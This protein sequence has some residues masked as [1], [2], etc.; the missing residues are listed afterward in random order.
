MTFLF[1]VLNVTVFFGINGMNIKMV[2]GLPRITSD[3]ASPVTLRSNDSNDVVSFHDDD[4]LKIAL[5]MTFPN[6]GTTYTTHLVR[7]VTGH[8][9]A[10]N[11]GPELNGN[12]GKSVPIFELSPEGPFWSYASDPRF[13][14]P[15][16]GYILTKTHCG[17]YC[18]ICPPSKYIENPQIFLSNC[19]QS[20][21]TDNINN[22]TIAKVQLGKYDKEMISKAVHLIRDPFDNIVARFHWELHK[23][24]EQNQTKFLQQYPN[25]RDGFRSFCSDLREKFQKEEK[26]SMFFNDILSIA[27]DVPCYADFFR[28]IQWHNH[29]FTMAWDLAVPTLVFHYENY[30]INFDE[31]KERLLR[32]L[33]M[34]ENHPAPEFITGKIYRD[35][36]TEDEVDAVTELFERL[37]LR[38]TWFY[39]RHYFDD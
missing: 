8:N 21:Y 34:K 20:Q 39:T 15:S 30:T 35:F 26:K 28:Y 32:F 25:N 12:D 5:F 10:T 11:Y 36:F 23:W 1:I 17:G 9:T 31:T 2:L 38:K 29:A 37:A 13:S 4:T 14:R 33:G 27:G 18:E 6:S 7:T 19:L 16:G 3:D 24:K 22:S